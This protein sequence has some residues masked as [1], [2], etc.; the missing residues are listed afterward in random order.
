MNLFTFNPFVFLRWGTS[1]LGVDAEKLKN[2]HNNRTTKCNNINLAP[3][4]KQSTNQETILVTTER[5]FSPTYQETKIELIAI[6]IVILLFC[7]TGIPSEHK[8][9]NYS[10]NYEKGLKMTIS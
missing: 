7:N 3:Q 5:T 1:Q 2:H 8:L 6:P 10:G 9:C 4:V